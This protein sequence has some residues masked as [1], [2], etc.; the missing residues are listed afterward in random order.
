METSL[1]GAVLSGARADRRARPRAAPHAVALAHALLHRDPRVTGE[2]AFA[3]SQ[4]C[5]PAPE[6]GQEGHENTASGFSERALLLSEET[7]ESIREL[8]GC[9]APVGSGA[10]D[11]TDS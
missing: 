7:L 1:S 9:A 8:I 3:L 4:S 11:Q 6:N 2:N 10:D 5:S